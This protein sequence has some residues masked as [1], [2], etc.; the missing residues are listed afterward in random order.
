ML[1]VDSNFTKARPSQM[2]FNNT[3]IRQGTHRGKEVKNKRLEEGYSR[4]DADLMI[5]APPLQKGESE[6]L[7]VR[8]KPNHEKSWTRRERRESGF[9]TRRGKRRIA[10]G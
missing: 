3:G 6:A 2:F 5:V 4:Q 8:R 9:K 10:K 7:K 1:K